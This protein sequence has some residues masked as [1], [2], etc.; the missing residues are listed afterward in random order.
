MALTWTAL[1]IIHSS[2]VFSLDPYSGSLSRLPLSDSTQAQTVPRKVSDALSCCN[3]PFRM[4]APYGTGAA[5]PLPPTRIAAYVS[6]H[7]L[8]L[9]CHVSFFLARVYAARKTPLFEDSRIAFSFFYRATALRKHTHL[10]L[11][12]ALFV[13]KT[14]S[15]FAAAGVVFIG[16]FLPMRLLHAWVVECRSHPD[17]NDVIWHL[18][19]PVAALS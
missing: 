17:P 16:A 13:A 12:R 9:L 5:C 15:S 4:E 14:S 6:A 1:P 2:Q 8:V 19:R 18:Y 11:P 7:T 3:E 10:C